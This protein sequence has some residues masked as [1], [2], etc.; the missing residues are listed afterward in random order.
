M[1]CILVSLL[2]FFVSGSF[3]F[4]QGDRM[5]IDLDSKF[6]RTP[7]E[8]SGSAPQAASAS[9]SPPAA[10][11]DDRFSKEAKCFTVRNLAEYS[12]IG[13][14]STD[15]EDMPSG[16]LRHRSN[17]RLAPKQKSEFCTRGPFYDG[18]KVELTIRTLVPIFDCR[19]RIH[20]EILI[21]GRKKMDGSYDTRAVC[22]K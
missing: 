10:P 18:E 8:D 20:K 4:A 19:T 17:F 11:S 12:V 7:S 15:Y 2:M 14:V 1:R 16:R 22:H 6:G 13:D 3:A 5:S 21:L 9:P